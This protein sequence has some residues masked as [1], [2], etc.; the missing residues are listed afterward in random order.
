MTG[1]RWKVRAGRIF[2]GPNITRLDLFYLREFV[3]AQ[4]GATGP[5]RQRARLS[6]LKVARCSMWNLLPTS[7]SRFLGKAAGRLA[8]AGPLLGWLPATPAT[9][10]HAMAAAASAAATRGSARSSA[11]AAALPFLCA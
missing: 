7:D 2:V 9:E 10:A 5:R 3:N 8:N 11:A 6:A 4:N 1:Q